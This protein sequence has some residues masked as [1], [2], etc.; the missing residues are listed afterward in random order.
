VISFETIE[1]LPE[2]D[3]PRMLAEFARVLV[4]EGLLLLSSPNKRRYSDDRAY[5]NP[6]HLH[7]LYPADLE[8]LLDISFPYRPWFPHTP[9]YAPLCSLPGAGCTRPAR[10]RPPC[11]AKI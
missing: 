10:T 6:F 8:P 7:E 5:R 4:P 2:D 3:Q 11:G 1:H 9:R